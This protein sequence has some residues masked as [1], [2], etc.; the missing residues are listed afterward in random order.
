MW[1][2]FS[3]SC[4]VNSIVT[5]GMVMLRTIKTR[6]HGK[7]TSFSHSFGAA[8]EGLH[9][10]VA[11]STLPRSAKSRGRGDAKFEEPLWLDD[12]HC[13]AL[14]PPKR[15]EIFPISMANSHPFTILN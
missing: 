14:D 15:W 5:L 13:A 1:P 7:K 12:E 4:S 6:E 8:N 9:P 11:Y 2:A 3:I 10:V